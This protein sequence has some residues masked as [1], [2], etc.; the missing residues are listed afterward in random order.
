MERPNTIFFYQSFGIRVKD[1]YI[2]IYVNTLI[3]H[4]V[5]SAQNVSLVIGECLV[6]GISTLHS[7]PNAP[8][9]QDKTT[10]SSNS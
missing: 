9:S 10:K 2:Y 8:N 5:G 6:I 7:F 3:C 1:V 4:K